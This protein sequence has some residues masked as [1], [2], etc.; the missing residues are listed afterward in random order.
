MIIYMSG[1]IFF[2][3]GSLIVLHFLKIILNNIFFLFKENNNEILLLGIL[4]YLFS[5]IFIFI[6]ELEVLKKLYQ[7]KYPLI[8]LSLI[9]SNSIFYLKKT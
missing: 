2:N 8:Y 3:L 6:T 5:L 9:A 1:L 7:I 4:T